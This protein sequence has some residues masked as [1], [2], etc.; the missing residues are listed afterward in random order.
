VSYPIEQVH[1]L[2]A[3][4]FRRLLGVKRE[5]FEAMLAALATREA[6]QKKKGRPADL[7]LEQQLLLALPFWRE[8][9]TH[10]HLAAEWQVAENTV[11]RTLQRVENTLV[12]SGAFALPGRRK[13]GG[14]EPPWQVLA[15]DVTE[16]PVERPKKSSAP[17]T[18]AR[19]S[20]TR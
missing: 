2:S 3:P 12:K 13:I 8:Y 14:V 19:R 7:T 4:D 6:A 20:A 11:R 16:S 1:A 10:Y 17:A 18:R 5:T 15:V 9:R